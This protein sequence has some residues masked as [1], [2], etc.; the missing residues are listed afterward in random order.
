MQ[1]N[2]VALPS[3]HLMNISHHLFETARILPDKTAIVFEG[4]E[5]SYAQIAD[6][7]ISAAVQLRNA[8]LQPG[9]RVA[10][11]LGNVPAFAVWYYAILHVGGIAVS[12]S[13]R[14]ANDEVDFMTSDSGAKILVASES[15]TVDREHFPSTINHAF[16]VSDDASFFNGQPLHRASTDGDDAHVAQPDDPALILYTSGTTG[17]AKGATLSHQNVRSNVYAFNHLCGQSPRSTV[18][19]AVPLFHCFGQN[20]LLNSC[21]HAGS[22]IVLQ[23]KFD[24]SETKR[25]I[26]DHAVTQLYG[27]PAMFQMLA[28]NCSPTDLATVDYCFSAATTLPIQVAD[29]WLKK[30]GMPI[31]EGYGLT[32]TSPFASYNHRLKFV[33]GSIGT[34]IDGC[35]MK[36]VDTESG[37]DCEPGTVGEI[38]ISGPNVMLGYW[39]H[40]NETAEAIRDGWFYS[41]DLGQQDEDGFFYIVDRVKDMISVG[42]LKVFPA[43]VER[44]LLDMDVI[45]EV[46]VVGVSGAVLGEQV[47]AWVVVNHEHPDAGSPNA[48]SPNATQAI[49]SAVKQYAREHLANYKVPKHVWLIDELPRNPSGKI[50]KKVLRDRARSNGISADVDSVSDAP[51]APTTVEARLRAELAAAYPSEAHRVAQD[52]LQNVIQAITGEDVPPA[53]DDGL[54]ESGLDSLMLVELSHQIQAEVGPGTDVSPTLVFDYPRVIDLAAFL[55]ST[56]QESPTSQENAVPNPQ[57]NGLGMAQS[58]IDGIDA[59]DAVDLGATDIATMTEDEVLEELMRELDE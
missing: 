45:S 31:Y 5:Y 44:V 55:V 58:K 6:L 21:F 16:F 15:A 23:R 34:P 49:K 26:K 41:G 53:V 29:H 18:L 12:L 51:E 11:Q 38:V 2:F 9:D 20:A 36:I 35:A 48:G 37:A 39:N 7:S 33:P 50:L 10:L 22:T 56:I 43:E 1:P 47:G 59:V 3:D 52:Y 32:E 17:F 30:Y 4:T 28:Q 54:L 57:T 46:A 14:L 40:P 13:A 8:G 42:G 19:V 27:V 25:L 24:P